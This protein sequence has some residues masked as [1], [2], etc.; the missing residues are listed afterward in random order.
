MKF[1]YVDSDL[2][3]ANRSPGED[4]LASVI[5]Q[6]HSEMAEKPGAKKQRAIVMV[7]FFI[8]L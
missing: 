1:Y 2:L 7:I 3:V 4:Y 6:P 5:L 8:H